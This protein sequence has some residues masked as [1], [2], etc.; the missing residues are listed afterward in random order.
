[1]PQPF[2]GAALANV[3][4]TISAESKWLLIHRS[5]PISAI[6]KRN[7]SKLTAFES[8]RLRNH[9]ARRNVEAARAKESRNH[10]RVQIRLSGARSRLADRKRASRVRRERSSLVFESRQSAVSQC[11]AQTILA[12][13]GTAAVRLQY[14][15]NISL[16]P[17]RAK[18]K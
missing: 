1:V 5:K 17:L 3:V 2:G 8:I 4:S 10:F 13:N 12:S 14:I 15:R 11:A 6:A 16:D 18:G 9:S 7:Q